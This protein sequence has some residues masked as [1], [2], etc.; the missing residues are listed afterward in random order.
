MAVTIP[1]GEHTTLPPCLNCQVHID[2]AEML[3]MDLA[4]K[5][6]RVRELERKLY[7][8]E[9]AQ[10]EKKAPNKL[11]EETAEFLNTWDELR[12][13]SFRDCKT[14]GI[15][16]D[17]TRAAR[18]RKAR[19]TWSHEDLMKCVRGLALSDWHTS[20]KKFFDLNS[21]LREDE[22]IEKHIA[23]WEAA[24][25]LRKHGFD[26][27]DFIRQA[28]QKPLTEPK[29]EF[30]IPRCPDC[31]A[32]PCRCGSRVPRSDDGFS[33]LPGSFPTTTTSTQPR[34]ISPAPGA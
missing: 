9:N 31:E 2:Y 10:E 11:S 30:G 8:L 34:A 4:I 24:E 3:T 14:V 17:S 32:D 26:N 33:V 6:R 18:Y 5:D 25:S 1:P 28:V 19:K 22:R 20:D 7:R 13:K 21:F 29:V 23:R 12:R 15:G 16:P 27:E